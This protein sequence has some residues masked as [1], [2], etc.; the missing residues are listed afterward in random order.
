MAQD[1]RGLGVSV[2]VRG[3]LLELRAHHAGLALRARLQIQRQFDVVDGRLQQEYGAEGRAQDRRLFPEKGSAVHQAAQPRLPRILATRP[4]PR[5]RQAHE[6]QP[7]PHVPQK[8]PSPHLRCAER[9]P[10]IEQVESGRQEVKD[11]A[12]GDCARRGG[13]DQR[14]PVPLRSADSRP[15]L[16]RRSHANSSPRAAFAHF[17][18][19]RA[20]PGPCT[21]GRGVRCPGVRSSLLLG[22]PSEAGAAG[23]AARLRAVPL[24]G[25][26]FLACSSHISCRLRREPT[27][28]SRWPACTP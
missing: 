11:E 16:C 28:L 9:L 24:H 3:P 25:F 14:N 20:G 6:A 7:G 26:P 22:L 23:R 12:E 21:L 18:Y 19:A 17:P 2:L 4:R 27:P 8:R 13:V 10:A 5:Q 15:C 1:E